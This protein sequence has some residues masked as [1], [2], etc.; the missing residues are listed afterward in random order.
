[1]KNLY[2]RFLRLDIKATDDT[3][4]IYDIEMQRSIEGAGAERARYHS[5][6]IDA[7]LLFSGEKTK[8]LPG[9]HVI[10][11]VDI[12]EIILRLVY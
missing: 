6:L 12:T 3:G 10:L 7:N 4:K 1:M 11:I 2:G 8:N 5:S 9:T